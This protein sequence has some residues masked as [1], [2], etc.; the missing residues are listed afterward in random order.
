MNKW[1]LFIVLLLAFVV[2]YIWWNSY[3]HKPLT[4]EGLVTYEN[5]M[6]EGLAEELN[7]DAYTNNYIY[8]DWVDRDGKVHP[9]VGQQ[10]GVGING[11]TGSMG[12]YGN[13]P[14]DDISLVTEEFFAP[15]MK[16][17]D[18]YFQNAGFL[19]NTLNT[20]LEPDEMGMTYSGYDKDQFKCFTK[21]YRQSDPFGYFFCGTIDSSQEELMSSFMGLF[22][23]TQNSDGSISSFRIVGIDGN[24]ASGSASV[25]GPGGYQFIAKN[26]DGTWSSI[27]EGQDFPLC[28][29]MAQYSVPSSMYPGC[30]DPATEDV[31]RVY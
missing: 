11:S 20:R 18:E 17:S 13:I 8:Y 2:G 5:N 1:F 15:L 22:P 28:S 7:T 10:F 25:G 23:Y 4:E 9:L 24:F 26:I 6:L 12:K 19:L 21:L 30:Y 3:A 31:K 29:D 14:N 27:W 16:A